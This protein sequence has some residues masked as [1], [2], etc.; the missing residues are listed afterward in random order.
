MSTG[1]I[2]KTLRGFSHA[3]SQALAAEEA[4][5][6]DGLLQALDARVKVVGMLS[7]VVAAALSRHLAPLV[8]LFAAG[9]AL[10]VASRLSFPGLVKRVWLVAFAFTAMIA[11]PALFLTPGSALW[12]LGPLT[13]TAQG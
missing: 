4:A 2:T 10:A 7:L 1:A 13:V 9:V 11:A 5:R 8:A 12:Q 6:A 3:L